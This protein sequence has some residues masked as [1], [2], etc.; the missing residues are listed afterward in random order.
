MSVTNLSMA[1]SSTLYN[2]GIEKKSNK[3]NGGIE[4]G[5][6]SNGGIEK[7]DKSNAIEW[8]QP[9]HIEGERPHGDSDHTLS[10]VEKLD[11]LSV[12][13]EV[14]GVLIVEEVD[15]VLVQTKGEGFQEGDV[16]RHHLCK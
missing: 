9:V 12:Q 13:G 5:N 7:S 16:I 1:S 14:V 15:G 8:W 6:K 11:G 10:V 2:G 3:G 4:K